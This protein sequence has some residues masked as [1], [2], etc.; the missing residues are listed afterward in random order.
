[1]LFSTKFFHIDHLYHDHINIKAEKGTKVHAG[2]E[3]VL[4]GGQDN[5]QVTLEE[6]A[7][8]VKSSE[9]QVA[10]SLNPLLPRYCLR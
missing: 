1:V 2:D 7:A 8:R 6:M 4:I 9:Y 5:K 3:V 10:G